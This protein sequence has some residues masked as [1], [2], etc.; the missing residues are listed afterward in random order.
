MLSIAVLSCWRSG[1]KLLAPKRFLVLF[2]LIFQKLL[3]VCHNAYEFSLPALN[4]NYLADRKQRTKIN[5]SYSP[6]SDLLFGV[7]RGSIFGP[8]LF[9]TFLSDLFL[10]AKDVNMASYADDNTLWL[11][12]YYRRSHIIITKF[13]QKTFSMVIR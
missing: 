13:N 6:W 5:H 9:N 3:T 8:L 2:W 11:V 4:P 7:A 1:K 12:R 10:I